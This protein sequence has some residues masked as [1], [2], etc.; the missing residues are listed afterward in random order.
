ML[1]TL[2]RSRWPTA[3]FAILI[4]T[5]SGCAERR[6]GVGVH[7][8]VTLGGLPVAEGSIAF[9]PVEGT[10]GQAVASEIRAGLYHFS[11]SDGPATGKHRVEISALKR[12]GKMI[13]PPGMGQ[14]EEIVELIPAAFNV[15]SQE[16]RD[17][18]SS[19]NEFNFDIP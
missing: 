18:A 10:K 8:K 11:P 14:T 13:E 4:A 7:G 16:F 6:D 1:S 15:E 2:R 9:I 5:L 12:T 3:A 17:V 19:D